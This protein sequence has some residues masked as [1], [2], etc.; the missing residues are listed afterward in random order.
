VLSHTAL[1]IV[2][3]ALV[4]SSFPNVDEIINDT[5]TAPAFEIFPFLLIML[6]LD[7]SDFLPFSLVQ[8]FPMI[9]V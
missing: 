3:S 2:P 7:P 6:Q 8:S 1:A 5:P 4:L 9:D